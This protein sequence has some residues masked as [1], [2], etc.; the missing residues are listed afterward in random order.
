MVLT[1]METTLPVTCTSL[2]KQLWHHLTV[3]HMTTLLEPSGTILWAIL[4][5]WQMS[6]IERFSIFVESIFLQCFTFFPYHWIVW[7]WILL[8]YPCFFLLCQ[9]L[10]TLQLPFHLLEKQRLIKREKREAKFSK[11][12][13]NSIVQ[14]TGMPITRLGR[15]SKL[16]SNLI[17]E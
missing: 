12:L 10:K 2:L 15:I 4:F 11:C 14:I 9:T 1:K 8:F 16:Y 7:I 3:D 13:N 6:L 17:V 5:D